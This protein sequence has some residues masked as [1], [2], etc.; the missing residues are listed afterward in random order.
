MLD[1]LPLDELLALDE[2]LLRLEQ[3]DARKAQVVRLK[4][5]AG[6]AN[7]DVADALGVSETTVKQDW[8]FARAWL[9][10]ELA[11]ND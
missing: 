3:R 7:A 8:S 6:L 2:A 10:R 11:H 9:H 1:A 5:F 4:F